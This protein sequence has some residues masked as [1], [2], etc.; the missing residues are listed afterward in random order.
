MKDEQTLDNI[1]N[2]TDCSGAAAQSP[3]H[4]WSEESYERIGR[5]NDETFKVCITLVSYMRPGIFVLLPVCC[6][7]SIQGSAWYIVYTWQIIYR[8]HFDK[9]LDAIH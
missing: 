6:I 7:P 5:L 9:L 1:E 3:I 2:N 8:M 4:Y